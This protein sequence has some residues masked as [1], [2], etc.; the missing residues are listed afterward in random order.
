M[1]CLY[2][3]FLFQLFSKSIIV[4]TRHQ[5]PSSLRE[6]CDWAYSGQTPASP[7][8]APARLRLLS[9][10]QKT[11]EKIGALEVAL[12]YYKC[13]EID[14]QWYGFLPPSTVVKKANISY[15]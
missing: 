7:M 10:R 12:C 13:L 15:E 3:G 4:L 2:G 8:S 14:N 1:I 11:G 9:L 5:D 6:L